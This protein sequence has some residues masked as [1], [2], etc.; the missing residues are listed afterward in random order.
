MDDSA[1]ECQ[2]MGTNEE[3]EILTAHQYVTPSMYGNSKYV[4]EVMSFFSKWI[5]LVKFK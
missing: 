3:N 1:L 5:S 2:L 4:N